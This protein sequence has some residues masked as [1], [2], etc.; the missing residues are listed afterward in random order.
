MQIRYDGY[1]QVRGR[2][3]AVGSP[4]ARPDRHNRYE[5]TGYETD[6]GSGLQYAG[7]R[8]NDPDLGSFLTHDPARQFAS[9]YTYTNRDPVNRVDPSGA[10]A[11]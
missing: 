5:F 10:I 8:F 6:S 2:F 9:P 11:D 7:A 1:G 3:D 4:V